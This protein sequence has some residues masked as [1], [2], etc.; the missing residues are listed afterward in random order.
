MAQ[1]TLD[2]VE[3]A[4]AGKTILNGVSLQ[5]KRGERFALVGRNGTGK[6]SLLRLAA[7]QLSPDQG[8]VSVSGDLRVGYLPQT[9]DL[10]DASSVLDAVVAG[11]PELMA[12]MR[13]IAALRKQIEEGSKSAEASLGQLKERYQQEGGRDLEQRAAIALQNVGF[14]QDQFQTATGLL[15]AGERSRLLLARVLVMD[16]DLLLLDEP[17]HHLDLKGIEFLEQYLAGFTGAAVVV[18]HDRAFIDHFATGIVA[19]GQDGS[20]ASYP[21]NYEKFHEIRAQQR[22]GSDD[23]EQEQAPALRFA[24]MEHSGKIV[25]QVRDLVLRPG[26][27]ILLE[28]SSFQVG[29]GEHLGIVGPAGSGKTALLK[30]L[31]LAEEPEQGKIQ[32]GY[33]AIMGIF[34]QDLSGLATGRTVLEELASCRPDLDDAALRELADHFLFVGDQV[35]RKVE[36]F[37]G[38]EQS[39]LV[40]MLLVMGR[41]NVLLLDEPTDQL[42]LPS[43]EVLEEALLAFPGTVLVVS[44]DRY[45]LDRIAQRILSIESRALVDEE[46]RFTALR[47]KAKIMRDTPKTAPALDPNQTPAAEAGPGK[48]GG[49]APGDDRNRLAELTK[50]VEKQ[51]KKIE[52]LVAK[53]ADPTHSLDW[54]WLEQVQA[55]KNTLE[56]ELAANQAEL[57]QLA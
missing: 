18:S 33:R 8:E 36:S 55:D 48:K 49:R 10:E 46:G 26:G 16:A 7:G 24:E 1:L 38:G 28:R 50:L 15:S 44:H 45:F 22:K 20:L 19:L 54:E 4:F 39:R 29:Q 23:G 6:S 12:L 56:K 14:A 31:S 30:T 47:K 17:T 27:Q 42:D 11:R 34:D 40:L 41:Y 5:V 53:M 21:G 13:D 32:H 25:F 57:G 52:S 9:P 2:K 35:E 43:R 3:L 51:K 37:S